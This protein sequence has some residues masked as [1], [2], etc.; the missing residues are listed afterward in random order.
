VIGPLRE[1]CT[2][3]LLCWPHRT[4]VKR[5]VSGTRSRKTWQFKN[6]L[7]TATKCTGQVCRS[8]G[9]RARYWHGSSEIGTLCPHLKNGHSVGVYYWSYWSRYRASVRQLVLLVDFVPHRIGTLCP[10]QFRTSYSYG[11]LAVRCVGRCALV[12]L[13]GGEVIAERDKPYT[14]AIALQCAGLEGRYIPRPLE[15]RPSGACRISCRTSL[16][17]AVPC[18]VA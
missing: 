6:G 15:G 14:L 13:E 5:P 8:L 9:W 3:P 18:S 4:Q 7:G 1:V 11:R 2:F 17:R 16:R 10:C 12:L